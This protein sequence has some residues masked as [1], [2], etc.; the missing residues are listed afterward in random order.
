MPTRRRRLRQRLRRARR[1]LRPR[2]RREDHGLR[3]RV[4]RPAQL[5]GRLRRQGASAEAVRAR[6]PRAS[7]ALRSRAPARWK[8]TSTASQRT[9]RCVPCFSRT[10]PTGSPS[11]R[12]NMLLRHGV[13]SC[14]EYAK[15]GD[16]ATAHGALS[17]PDLAPHLSFVDLGGHGYAKVRADR[18][19][20]AHGIR[21]H[22]AAA[23]A[24]RQHRWRTPALS[25]R[26]C[27]KAL[28]GR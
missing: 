21:V 16:L 1:D 26:A 15:S 3:H 13:R 28:A 8:R 17:N 11:G 10:G 23:G 18:G 12:I 24:Q 6:R 7:S 9:I 5:L 25:R 19:R 2:A 4:G 22:T 20:D 14:L 27:R